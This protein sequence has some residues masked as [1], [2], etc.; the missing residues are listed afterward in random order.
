MKWSITYLYRTGPEAAG[1]LNVTETEL[2]KA[3]Q[4]VIGREY[5][6][7]IVDIQRVADVGEVVLV[8]GGD[9]SIPHQVGGSQRWHKPNSGNGTWWVEIDEQGEDLPGLWKH[10][11]TR[12]VMLCDQ[13]NTEELYAEKI[14]EMREDRRASRTC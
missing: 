11:E 8:E 1:V 13:D 14:R 2:E 3:L 6:A 5:A 4:E 10:D 12:N 9:Q 7:H